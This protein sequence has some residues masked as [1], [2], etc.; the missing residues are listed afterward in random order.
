[1]KKKNIV[2]NRLL[3]KSSF[4]LIF[5]II[6]TIVSC[7]NKK[8]QNS[9]Q[10]VTQSEWWYSIIQKH[11]IDLSNFNYRA[12]FNCIDSNRNV[13]NKWLELGNDNGSDE[14]YLK[15]K[16]ALI[17]VLFDTT[18]FKSSKQN[19]W[20]LTSPSI[21]QDFERKTIDYDWGK[22]IW[23]DVND[24]DIIPLD[25][26]ESYGKIDFNFGLKIAPESFRKINL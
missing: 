24:K 5:C 1:M 23:Y 3:R 17:I 21:I 6:L 10:G 7:D 16:D 20:I 2:S 19:Y 25:T 22:T 26:F 18:N 12:T 4:L 9:S 13:I 15:L 14:K 11:N 8:N